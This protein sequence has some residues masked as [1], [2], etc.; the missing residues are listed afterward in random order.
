[1]ASVDYMAQIKKYL[2]GKIGGMAWNTLIDKIGDRIGI[3]VVTDVDG[4]LGLLPG[5]NVAQAVSQFAVGYLWWLYFEGYITVNPGLNPY[6]PSKEDQQDPYVEF[7]L[8]SWY[9]TGK[10]VYEYNDLAQYFRK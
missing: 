10:P 7:L 9:R 5:A 3:K 4:L 8:Y 2:V 1:M 6:N